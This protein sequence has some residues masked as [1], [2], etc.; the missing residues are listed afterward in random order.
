MA[1]LYTNI[2]FIGIFQTLLFKTQEFLKLTGVL[3]QKKKG[4]EGSLWWHK[5]LNEDWAG[6]VRASAGLHGPAAHRTLIPA[7]R[8]SRRVWPEYPLS[9]TPIFGI[10]NTFTQGHEVEDSIRWILK[11]RH[12]KTGL[13]VCH[14]GSSDNFASATAVGLLVITHWVNLKTVLY[15]P[16]C[17]SSLN[18]LEFILLLFSFLLFSLE[19]LAH[20]F[21]LNFSRFIGF[22]CLLKVA[23]GWGLFCRLSR[24]HTRGI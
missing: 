14:E 21:T 4:G 22:K 7:G 9:F 16:Y 2:L 11:S 17:F 23:H 13:K 15:L 18:S 10:E 20:V 24:S 12:F 5:L 6:P 1:D 8:R 3:W 19:I